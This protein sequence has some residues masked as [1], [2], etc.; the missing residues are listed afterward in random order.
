M[1]QNTFLCICKQDILGLH[2]YFLSFFLFYQKQ[3]SIT[4][5]YF[6]FQLQ[7]LY[8]CGLNPSISFCFTD[9]LSFFC[10]KTFYLLSR[11]QKQKKIIFIC[12]LSIYVMRIRQLI[13][14]YIMF[15]FGFYKVNVHLIIGYNINFCLQSKTVYAL[16]HS[17]EDKNVR[18]KNTIMFMYRV[19]LFVCHSTFIIR[20]MSLHPWFC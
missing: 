14:Q 10:S 6:S 19:S 12:I 13:A 7:F 4:G 15:I 1:R 2:K 11:T 9:F 3:P 20:K 18:N 16:I 17:Q 8:F 5:L